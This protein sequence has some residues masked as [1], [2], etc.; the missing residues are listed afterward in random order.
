RRMHHRLTRAAALAF[1]AA[2]LSGCGGGLGGPTQEMCDVKGKVTVNGRPGD[3]LTMTFTPIDPA[4]GREDVCTVNNGDY[5][6]KLMA[7]KYKVSFEPAAGGSNV[8]RQYRSPA[9]TTLDID[10]T[11]DTEKSFDLK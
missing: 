3:R 9:S 4:K 6:T 2:L 11:R 10:A 7:G 5:T 1:A 8:P